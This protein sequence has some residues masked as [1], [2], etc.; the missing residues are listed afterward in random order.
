VNTE[1]GC[2]NVAT[3]SK[4]QFYN[5]RCELN[6]TA[7]C[8]ITFPY[9]TSTQHYT[10]RASTLTPEGCPKDDNNNRFTERH[11]KRTDYNKDWAILELDRPVKGA[12]PYGIPQRNSSLARVGD[13]TFYV[14]SGDDNY[15]I[16]DR[17]PFTAGVCRFRDSG[18]FHTIPLQTDCKGGVGVSGSAHL[19]FNN[20][21]P[22]VAAIMVGGTKAPTPGTPY[23]P[24]TMFNYSKPLEDDF[25]EAVYQALEKNRKKN[26]AMCRTW[27]GTLT[28]RPEAHTT[29]SARARAIG[30]RGCPTTRP[31][32]P[33][34]SLPNPAR[35]SSD[36]NGN[37]AGRSFT[38]D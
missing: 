11:R 36:A 20:R 17:R 23:H 21:R 27:F 25:L 30:H 1:N 34:R 13:E 26:Q 19:I 9:S 37:V 10:I 7:T 4:H 35:A 12:E 3:T 2:S 29:M 32:P 22:F 38:P 31:K 14:S 6:S 5:E 28:L 33:P 24:H 15:I 16:N 18:I 8:R